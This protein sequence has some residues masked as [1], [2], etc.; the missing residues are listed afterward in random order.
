MDFFVLICL[1]PH[2]I[3]RRVPRGST[4]PPP[5]P[6]PPHPPLPISALLWSGNAISRLLRN[7]EIKKFGG[8]RTSTHQGAYSAPRPPPPPQLNKLCLVY[9]VMIDRPLTRSCLYSKFDP[10]PIKNPDYAP[11]LMLYQQFLHFLSNVSIFPEFH[12]GI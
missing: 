1:N 7:A 4:S 6:P 12:L 11:D 3:C 9:S 5:P 10:R 2:S 8:L